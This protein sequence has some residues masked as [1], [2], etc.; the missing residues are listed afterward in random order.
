MP[1]RV[2]VVIPYFQERPGILARTLQSVRRQ[3]LHA[4]W[5]VDVIVVDDGSPSPASDE[6]GDV[7]FDGSFRL[8]LIRQANGGVAA[9]RN[10]GL[11]AVTADTNLVAFL[12]SDDAWPADHL[13]RAVQAFLAG[14]DFYFTDHCRDGHHASYLAECATETRKLVA[15]AP[16]AE[17][18]VAIS[19][20]RMVWLLL[21]ESPIQT[22]TL[23]FRRRTAPALRFNPALTAAGEDWLFLCML[24]AA[25]RRPAF[26]A[27]SRVACGSGLNIYWGNFGWDSPRCLAIRVD[28]L[29][30]HRLVGRS[31]PLSAECMALNRQLVSQ[32]GRD[33][34]FH[35]VRNLVKAPL[36]VPA[37]MARLVAV[38]ARAAMRLPID[39][40]RLVGGARLT[41]PLGMVFDG[42]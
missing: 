13:A 12:D 17:G 37:A 33:L 35:V 30:A 21:R 29:A 10:R 7:P 36:R 23:V 9:A 1:Y 16:S 15:A 34:A 3:K 5:C 6:I 4:N 27:D 28:Q 31:V 8:R 39:M 41:R 24:A 26:D 2:S 22:S 32:Y 19:S 42:T 18:F 25:A 20:S 38:D 40:L 11:D 14:F